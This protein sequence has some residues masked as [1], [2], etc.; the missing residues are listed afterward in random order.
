MKKKGFTLIELLVVIAIIA[1][2]ASMLLPALSRAREQARRSVCMSNLKQIGLALKMYS[3]DYDESFPYRGGP[4]LSNET[5]YAMCYLFGRVWNTTGPASKPCP[6]YL[7]NTGMIVCPSARDIKYNG[8]PENTTVAF[9]PTFSSDPNVTNDNCSYAY[10]CGLDEQT[11]VESV[12][13][14]DKVSGENSNTLWVSPV[15][16]RS[17]LDNHGGDGINVL[18]VGGNASWVAADKDGNLDT[19]KLGNGQ[20]TVTT[21]INANGVRNP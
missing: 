16:V 20:V 11:N 17:G 8:D 3:Q 2:L 12:I 4:T 21:A 1:I 15:T 19:I 18:Y 9:N 14:A 7:K 10:G 6:N 13:V 5:A